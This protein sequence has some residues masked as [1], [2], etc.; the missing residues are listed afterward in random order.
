[1][2]DAAASLPPPAPPTR[3]RRGWIRFLLVASLALNLFLVGMLAGG[4]LAQWPF[5]GFDPAAGPGFVPHLVRSLP[6]AA[7]TLAEDEFAD[8]RTAI[9]RQVVELRREHRTIYRVLAAEHFDRAAL[10]NTLADMRAKVSNL[11]LSIHQALIDVADQ[12]DAEGRQ[13]MAETLR[14]LGRRGGQGR[15][16][17]HGREP[18][19]H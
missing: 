3:R 7:R 12:L 18:P 11:Q 8:R 2:T 14:D 13:Q 6:P 19:V 4:R 1:M 10:E 9:R 16:P 17:G 5:V 15:G